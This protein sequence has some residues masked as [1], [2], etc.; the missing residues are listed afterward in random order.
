MYEADFLDAPRL[1]RHIRDA[2][3]RFHACV[4]LVG[5]RS[6]RCER[7]R[8]YDRQALGGSRRWIRLPA[9]PRAEVYDAA[10]DVFELKSMRLRGFGIRN[11]GP[12]VLICA[13][14]ALQGAATEHLIGT[15][16]QKLRKTEVSCRHLGLFISK[17]TLRQAWPKI[18][19]WIHERPLVAA[20]QVKSRPSNTRSE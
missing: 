10:Q 12:P 14:L 6:C 15:A 16:P 4:S 13:P 11:D 5:I 17:R 19:R 9:R 7:F 8:R 3:R 18:G 1:N 20:I 2:G